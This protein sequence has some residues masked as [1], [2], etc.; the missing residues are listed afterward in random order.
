MFPVSN[1]E[2]VANQVYGLLNEWINKNK[3]KAK[4]IYCSWIDK[5]NGWV[6]Y[7]H[8]PLN[9]KCDLCIFFNIDDIVYHMFINI[10]SN[11]NAIYQINARK[12]AL[13]IQ[14]KNG[15]I[16]YDDDSKHAFRV[17]NK[18]KKAFFI[19]V[20]PNIDKDNINSWVSRVLCCHVDNIISTV[21]H[22][23]AEIKK[24]QNKNTI[25]IK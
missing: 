20:V 6:Q 4:V 22:Q 15:L 10:K 5:P 8:Q 24:R 16:S 21:K 14:K 12:K 3:I 13:L 17:V 7:D 23:I 9:V 2:N 1:K 18:D 11:L 19:F 25:Y